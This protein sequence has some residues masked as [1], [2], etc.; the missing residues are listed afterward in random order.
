MPIARYIRLSA[1]KKTIDSNIKISGLRLFFGTTMLDISS[2]AVTCNFTP[3]SGT[4]DIIKRSNIVNGEAFEIP[5]ALTRNNSYIYIDL[6]S[7]KEWDA[8][9]IGYA[10]T[11]QNSLTK[12]R[13]EYSTNATQYY[14]FEAIEYKFKLK[15]TSPWS[16]SNITDRA[17]TGYPGYFKEALTNHWV[18]TNPSYI[19]RYLIL[20]EDGRSLVSKRQNVHHMNLQ[21]RDGSVFFSPVSHYLERGKY[22]FEISSKTGLNLYGGYS[23]FMQA[24]CTDNTGTPG[25]GETAATWGMPMHHNGIWYSLTDYRA[26]TELIGTMTPSFVNGVNKIGH[27]AGFSIDVPN[28]I[29]KLINSPYT[30]DFQYNNSS[31]VNQLKLV[32]KRVF[33]HIA[34]MAPW[35]SNV[36]NVDITFNFGHEPFVGPVPAGFDDRIGTRWEIEL[37]PSFNFA[38]DLSFGEEYHNIKT[39]PLQEHDDSFDNEFFMAPCSDKDV[40]ISPE[41]THYI[42]D[43]VTNKDGTIT[44]KKVLLF[45]YP[46]MELLRE[47]TTNSS[48]EYE[49]LYLED[50]RYA[51]ISQD[52]FNETYMDEIKAP[53]VPK[54]MV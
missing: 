6:G 44:K 8:F 47:T 41:L 38:S 49:F 40:L 15:F 27:V 48:G 43:K 9:Q 54:K 3:A 33:F 2:A 51:I 20:K 18:T 34:V 46:Q 24:C 30:T 13:L 16:F 32:R 26:S 50:R 23:L 28:G 12:L 4:L 21:S 1:N 19:Y 5:A 10:D 36:N 31:L 35:E 53:V 7:D 22:Y 25:A 14:I 45:F 42:R 39:T 37:D 52:L 29:V 17:T 11:D